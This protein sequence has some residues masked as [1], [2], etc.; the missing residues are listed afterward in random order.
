MKISV[1]RNISNKELIED[2]QRV[3]KIISPQKLTHKEYKKFGTYGNQTII[4][5]LGGWNNALEKAALEISINQTISEEEL[6][7]NLKEVWIKLGQQPSA[8]HMKKSIS[9]YSGWRYADKYG[10]WRKALEA[11]IKY[12]NSDTEE[13]QEIESNVTDVTHVG[14]LVNGFVEKEQGIEKESMELNDFIEISGDSYIDSHKE[15]EEVAHEL[16]LFFHQ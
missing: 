13:N 7:Q 14:A 9:K 11:F 6:F 8:I 2:L 12:I 1:N 3:A 16:K 4:R 15:I 5:N 10:S